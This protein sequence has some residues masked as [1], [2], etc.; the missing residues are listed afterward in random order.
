MA[1]QVSI[2][3]S[4]IGEPTTSLLRLLKNFEAQHK[5]QVRLKL[6]EWEKAWPEL[7]TFAL[8]GH[9]PDI[10]HIGS[11]WAG[12]LIAMNSLRPFA[13]REIAAL[14]GAEAFLPQTWQ[15]GVLQG[16]PEVW[17]LPW[18][19]FTFLL[20]YRRDILQKAGID[21]ITAFATAE[22]LDKTLAQLQAAGVE[23]DFLS[24]IPWVVPVD[25]AFV[26]ILHHQASWVWGAGGDYISADGRQV[27][28]CQ[29]NTWRGLCSYLS[30]L[31]FMRPSFSHLD[32]AA[33]LQL[34]ARGRAAV[35]ILGSGA[36]YEFVESRSAVPE[37]LD[38]LGVM[39]V[40]GVPWIG[41]DNLVIWK[42]TQGYPERERA[43]V[44][45]ASFLA[46]QASQREYAQDGV[47]MLPTRPD[48]FSALPFWESS[49]T[50]AV[51]RSL[52]TGRAYRAVAIWGRLE[53]QLSSTLGQISEAILAGAETDAA[54]QQY[55]EPLARRLEITLNS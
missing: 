2:E 9:G 10:S 48:S 34:F 15:S 39:P 30:L 21:E 11:T 6:M 42:H 40:P 28:L 33:A 26:D 23:Q 50:Q 53:S 55:L 7:L 12:S 38:N 20:C 49:L 35:T 1:E 14:G 22:A 37:V 5:V 54:L 27:M 51:I 24:C 36:V 13:P 8:Y 25:P 4:L 46:S 43:A 41:G 16:Q 17:S 31:R 47:V 32:E 44:A 18:T 3:F 45:L 52:Q 29:P 19:S